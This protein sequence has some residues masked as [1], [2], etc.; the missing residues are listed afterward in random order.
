MKEITEYHELFI[1]V[2]KTK[3]QKGQENLLFL[4]I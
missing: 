4:E 3:F 1:M 2:N